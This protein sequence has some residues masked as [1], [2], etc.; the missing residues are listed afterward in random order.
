[1]NQIFN[2]SQIIQKPDAYAVVYT[3]SGHV[4]VHSTHDTFT[5]AYSVVE[6]IRKEQVGGKYYVCWP[7][8]QPVLNHFCPHCSIE[9]SIL[10]PNIIPESPHGFEYNK[11]RNVYLK[12]EN[13]LDTLEEK[14]NN[15]YDKKNNNNNST[16]LTGY[17]KLYND[18]EL[19]SDPKLVVK[20]WAE[21]D[22][23]SDEENVIEFH[24]WL[25]DRLLDS[26][27]AVYPL[28][29]VIK[30]AHRY[31]MIFTFK[32]SPGKVLFA[33]VTEEESS[34]GIDEEVKFMKNEVLPEMLESPGFK[35]EL[36]KCESKSIKRH[37]LPV[38]PKNFTFK[39]MAYKR[40]VCF[41]IRGRNDFVQK[42]KKKRRKI[43]N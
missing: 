4:K 10:D 21:S 40:Y 3:Q 15:E 38:I 37:D 43:E 30:D 42:G 31:P 25:F 6:L 41:E 26:D 29:E 14:L 11:E 39:N 27:Y 2:M 9:T 1:M 22:L 35:Y 32:N 12:I 20:K 36:L 34:M 18:G 5:T 24:G 8:V 17:Q 13:L 33:L 7:L 16:D 23:F 19:V 28:S